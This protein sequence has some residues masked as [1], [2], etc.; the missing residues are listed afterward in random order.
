MPVYEY[1]ALDVNGKNT[2]GIVDA[3]SALGARQKL[4][5]SKIFPVSIKEVSITNAEKESKTF[6][7]LRFFSRSIKL[8]ELSMMTRHLATLV[9]A[10]FP[11]VSAIDTLIPQTG[12]HVF[13]KTLANI[14]DS[15]VEGKSFADALSLYPG[16]FSA[17]YINMVRSGETSGTLEIVLERLAD[18]AE[19]QQALRSQ[20]R[21]ALVYP[22]FMLII[23]AVVLFF[24]LAYIVP[25]ITSIFSDMNQILPAPT[26]F[27]IAFSDLFKH[28]WWV[29]FIVIFVAIF[30]VRSIKKTSK[31][32]YFFDKSLLSFPL[33]GTLAR[34]LAVA[35]F[36]RTLGSLLENG[37][38]MLHALEIVK[39]IVGNIIISNAVD[40]AAKDVEGGQGLGMVLTTSKVFP[41]LFTQMVKVGEQSGELEKML[42]KAADVYEN[43]IELS[44]MNI[45]SMLEPV[46]IL[47]MGIIVAFI[48]ISICLPIFEMN[49]LVV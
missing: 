48:V 42:K 10:G 31:G 2:S 33:I 47:I 23:G 35:R 24:L 34:K 4:R 16:V 5:D 1:T 38:P 12:S 27:L 14:K 40:T 18:I 25:N 46:M 15:I 21:S 7:L 11:L 17:I 8:S 32:S 22:V 49:Q 30:A 45:T 39:N 19:K 6:F 44:V 20:I 9:G 3:E 37:V 26:R 29:I 28:Y 43:E 36:S 41:N 13:K